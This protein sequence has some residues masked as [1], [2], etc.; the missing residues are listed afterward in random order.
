MVVKFC[1]GE[2]KYLL[3]LLMCSSAYA[4]TN[5]ELERKIDILADEIAQLKAS[6]Q[7]IGTGQMAYGLGQAASKVYFINQGLSIGGYGEIVYTNQASEDEDGNVTNREPEAEALRNIIYVG[8]KFND[9]WLVNIELEMEHVNEIYTEFMYV[10]YL[11]SDALSYR[12][13]LSLVPMGLINE[14]HEPIYFNSVKRPEIETYL[15][16]STWREIGVGAFGALGPEGKFT[17][18]AF[19]YNGPDADDIAANTSKGIRSGRKKGGSDNSNDNQNASTYAAVLRGDYNF[20]AST[21]VGGSLF[22]GQGSSLNSTNN[23]I[24]MDLNIIELHA[25]YKKR[26]FGVR[27]LYTQVDFANASEW[28]EI[29]QAS[30]LVPEQMGGYYLEFEYDLEAS[31][32][33]VYTP[34]VRFENYDLNKVVDEDT[35]GEKNKSLDRSNFVLG[36]AYKPLDR[37]VFKADYAYKSNGDESGVN[38]FNLGMGF[39]Y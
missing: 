22:T 31:K 32:G 39:V 11:A 7:N 9:K 29:A 5:A 36:V 2:M 16:P 24:D 35:F 38:E 12:F 25:Q 4:A 21:S 14:L 15:I 26:G 19:L 20:D 6:Q 30:H 8:Y 18:K 27:F 33:T 23:Y 28:N 37:M 13:G 34:F 10:D 1:G 17:Y 3:L